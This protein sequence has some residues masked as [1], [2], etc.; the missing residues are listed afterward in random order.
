MERATNSLEFRAAPVGGAENRQVVPGRVSRLA[1]EVETPYRQES[2]RSA[3]RDA[4]PPDD[5][6]GPVRFLVG[7]WAAPAGSS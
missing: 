4:P 6:L 7:F 2:D 3:G 5:D 1:S